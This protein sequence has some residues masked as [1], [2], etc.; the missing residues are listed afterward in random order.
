MRATEYED[1]PTILE[2][3]IRWPLNKVANG[4]APGVDNIPIELLKAAGDEGAKVLTGTCQHIWATKI[5]PEEW[6][7][8]V[9]I[10]MPKKG[11]SRECANNRTIALIPHASKIIQKRLEPIIERELPEVQAGFRHGRGCRDQITNVRWSMEKAKE[12]QQELFF[13]FIDYMKAFD[14]VDHN[15]LWNGLRY[16]GITEHLIVLIKNLY[17]NQQA[18]VRTDFGETELFSIRKGVRQG[19]ILLPYLLFCIV[20]S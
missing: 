17:D 20:I 16:L 3:E 13:C 12:R 5:W 6:K 8:S 1:E 15:T 2:S 7:Q 14:C 10:I 11:D 18:T 19:C 4:K 9:F